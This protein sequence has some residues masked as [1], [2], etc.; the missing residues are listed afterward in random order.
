M[1]I[2]DVALKL[3]SKKMLTLAGALNKTKDGERE[4]NPQLVATYGCGQ[5]YNNI[6]EV[7]LNLIIIWLTTTLQ[8]KIPSIFLEKSGRGRELC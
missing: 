3:L 2:G 6:T 1:Q 7:T 5:Q 8:A 4:R